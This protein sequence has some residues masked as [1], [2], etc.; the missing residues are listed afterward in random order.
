V[1]E[2]WQRLQVADVRMD[3][4]EKEI[5]RLISSGGYEKCLADV[6]SLIQVLERTQVAVRDGEFCL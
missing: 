6:D 4:I 3:A 5:S 1:E 2:S